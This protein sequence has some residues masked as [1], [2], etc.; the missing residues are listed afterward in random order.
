MTDE[1]KNV[2]QFWVRLITD[3]LSERL[4]VRVDHA[5]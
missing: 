4:F 1:V 3:I 5:L 2:P